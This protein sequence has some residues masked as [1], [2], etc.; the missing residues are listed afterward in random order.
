MQ[1]TYM[2]GNNVTFS[3]QWDT[4]CTEDYGDCGYVATNLMQSSA[5]YSIRVHVQM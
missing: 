2:I 3:T 1:D 5:V 4:P